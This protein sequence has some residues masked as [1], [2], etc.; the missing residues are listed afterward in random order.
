MP[1]GDNAY[2]YRWCREKHDDIDRE[3]G[4]VEKTFDT[5]WGAIRSLDRK[6]WGIIVLLVINFGGIIGILIK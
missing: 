2:N 3:F 6:L 4:R 1:N 5:V